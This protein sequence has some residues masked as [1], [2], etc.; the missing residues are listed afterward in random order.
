MIRQAG[1][2]DMG[3][4]LGIAKRAHV[5]AGFGGFDI[6]CAKGVIG[7]SRCFVGKGGLAGMEVPGVSSPEPAL[8]HVVFWDSDG[9]AWALLAAHE[10]ASPLP[11]SLSIPA[12]HGRSRGLKK[13]LLARGYQELETLMVKT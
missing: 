11:S 8:N 3:Y 10:A 5:H 7:A 6:E 12:Q 4:L 1:P 2:E 13:A 9:D